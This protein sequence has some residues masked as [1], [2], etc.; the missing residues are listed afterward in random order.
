MTLI[1]LT[2][3]ALASTKSLKEEAEHPM[4]EAGFFSGTKSIVYFVFTYV[5]NGGLMFGDDEWYCWNSVFRG[6]D[7]ILMMALVG[8]SQGLFLS[9]VQTFFQGSYLTED[10]FA[11]V[12][13]VDFGFKGFEFK[14]S[15]GSKVMNALFSGDLDFGMLRNEY[16][17]PQGSYPTT[18]LG[19]FLGLLFSKNWF[20]GVAEIAR[21]ANAFVTAAYFLILPASAGGPSS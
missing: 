14:D 19:I 17:A 20:L 6:L 21:M 11:C 4:L 15:R 7:L 1:L 13:N 2:T 10:V 18:E 16:W 5:L 12:D 9:M 3:F 8:K